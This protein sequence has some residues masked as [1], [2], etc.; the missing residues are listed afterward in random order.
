MTLEQNIDRRARRTRKALKSAFVALVLEKGY[1]SVTIL[2]VANRA[3]YNRGTFY[4][5]FVGKEDVLREIH[6]DLLLGIAKLLLEPYKGMERI[7]AAMTFPSSLRLFEHIEQHKDDFMALLSVER[8]KLA[9]ELYDR[10]RESMREDM[11]IEMEE[12]DPPIDY[13]I[14]LSYRMSATVGVIMHWAET[15][16][17]YSAAY[18]AEQLIALVDAKMDYIVFKRTNNVDPT[19]L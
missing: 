6:D 15:N 16:F 19:V 10:L 13:E 5:H 2:D 3:D 18:M 4:K 1:D 11:H 17:K 8:G 14:M 12:S 9:L 7:D